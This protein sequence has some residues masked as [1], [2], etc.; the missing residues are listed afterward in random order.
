MQVAGSGRD[1]TVSPDASAMANTLYELGGQ[2]AVVISQNI[3]PLEQGYALF[4]DTVSR[5]QIQSASIVA[6]L[7]GLG[8]G[9]LFLSSYPPV[10][11]QVTV[12]LFGS[13]PTF[14]SFIVGDNCRLLIDPD[15]MFPNG[16]DS[17]WRITAYQVKLPDEGDPTLQLTL[18]PP[19][20][21]PA[22]AFI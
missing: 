22:G 8:Y 21:Y 4:E 7:T 20:V 15:E 3:N 1:Y 11:F 16:L 2:N 13:D 14:G 9:D 12:P 17:E 5:S 6:M 19:P 18:S 10:T